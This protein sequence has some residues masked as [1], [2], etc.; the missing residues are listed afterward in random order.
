MPS[1]IRFERQGDELIIIVP[2]VR[3]LVLE[4]KAIAGKG[5]MFEDI[6]GMRIRPRRSLRIAERR[7]VRP[8]MNHLG[9]NA[10]L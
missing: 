3:N 6:Y 2:G 8:G 5:D 4:R 7:A 9:R 10:S 1:H